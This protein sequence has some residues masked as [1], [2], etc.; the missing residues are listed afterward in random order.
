[1]RADRLL[2]ILMLLQVHR[3]MT[4]RE[5]AVRLEVSERTIHRDMESL[6][7]TGVPVRADRGAGGGWSLPDGYETNLTGLN[8]A[9][10]Q[11]LFLTT[12]LRLLADLGL[13][14]ASQAALAKLQA[15]L[16][17]AARRDAEFVR[18][19]FHVDSAG[20]QRPGEDVSALPVLQ[21]AIWQERK[22]RMHY[23]RS[24]GSGSGGEAT[25][26]VVAPLG[27]VAKGS[28]WYLVAAGE[29]E[30]RTYRVSRIQGAAVT[31]EPFARPD[32]FDLRAHW[33][34]SSREFVEALPRY[35]V[36]VLAVPEIVGALKA[37]GRWSRVG[38]VGDP[39][40]DGR[41]P[42]TIRFESAG[43]ALAHC[44][45]FGPRLEVLEPAELRE[46]AVQ[47]AGELLRLYRV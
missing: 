18:Q 2:S 47:S 41:V 43:E 17:A 31:D 16:P 39:A 34:Q 32:G 37:G 45:S 30:P 29:G 8:Q 7:A 1:M 35:T 6:S 23:R 33:E 4:A 14:E 15:A 46:A 12:P 13:N 5:L 19:R 26:R 38:S 28:V 21:D 40:P 42:V 11:A 36:A 24:D 25:E 20:W 9:E 3:R 10:I 44:L 22:V 27:L